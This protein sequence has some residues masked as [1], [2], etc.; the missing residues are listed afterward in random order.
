MIKTTNIAHPLK[1]RAGSS[2][3][4][5]S[6]E[7]LSPAYAPIDDKTL[8]DRLF[9]ISKYASLINYYEIQK[10]PE[11][12]EYQQADNWTDFFEN[13]LPFKLA[14]FSKISTEDLEDRFSLL[15]QALKDNPSQYTLEALLNFIYNEIILSTAALYSEVIKSESS[16]S[17]AIL[18]IIKSSFQEPLRRFISL[19]NAATTLLCITR[20]KFDSFLPEP[21]GLSVSEIYAI[22]ICI[23]QVKKGK[24][25]GYFLAGEIA[26]EIFAQFLSGLAEIIEAAPDYIQES[27]Y[28]LEA[29]MQKKHE[30]HLAL[31]FTFLE[32]FKH[33]QGNINGLGK[34]HLDFFYKKVLQLIPKDAVPDKAHI[35]FEIAKHLENGY[36]LPKDLLLKDGKDANKQDIQFGL[37]QELILDKSKIKELRS[38]S[39]YPVKDNNNIQHIEGVYITNV[40]NSLDGKGEKFKEKSANWATLG[41]KYTKQ[42]ENGKEQPNE[43]PK[44]RLGFVLASPVLLLQEG[45]RQVTITLN[46]DLFD[47]EENL[48]EAEKDILIDDIE[49]KLSVSGTE[50]LYLLSEF[51]IKECDKSLA[52]EDKLSPGATKYVSKLLVAQD[53]F[54]IKKEKLDEFLKA[55]DPVSCEPLFTPNDKVQITNCLNSLGFASKTIKQP[56]FRIFFSGEK[57]WIE[58]SSTLSIIK[59][60]LGGA[61]DF[62]FNFDITLDPEVPPVVFYNEENLKEKFDL[63]DIFPLVKIELNEELKILC[64]NEDSREEKCCLRNEP[65][66]TTDFYISP[67]ELLQDMFITD[68]KIEVTVCGVKNL[69][70]QNDETLQDVNKPIMPFGPR[71]KVKSSFIIGSKEVFCKKWESFRLNLEWK[72]RPDDFNNY[73]EA[74]N[75]IPPP[76]ITDNIFE[77][78][79]NI[80]EDANWKKDGTKKLFIPKENFPPCPVVNPLPAHNGYVWNRADFPIGY[81]EK[82]MPIPPLVPFNI[83]SR[84]AF[85]RL[86]LKGED[87]QHDRYA[88]VLAQQMFKLSQVAD[89]IK[90]G[91][92]LDDVD[93]GCLLAT[94]A[95]T[96]VDT[97]ETEAGGGVGSNISQDLIDQ[98]FGPP[99]PGLDDVSDQLMNVVCGLRTQIENITGG[100]LPVLPNEPY[101]PLIKSLSID[102]K[103]VADKVDMELIHLYPYE[104]TS[105]HENIEEKPTLLPYF[106]DE[107][108]L[109]I[110]LEE[111]TAG[112]NLSLLF[113]LAEATADSEQNRAKINW[114]YLSNN[115]WKPL[116]PEFDILHDATDG[117]TVSGII[118]IALPDDIHKKGHSI[119]PDDVFWLKV[120]TPSN[121][122]AVAET[123]GI[124]TQAAL[125]SARFG[126]L[127]DKQRLDSPLPAGSISKTLNSDF[128]VKK[129][130]QLYDS[131][132]GRQPE[133]SGHFYVRVSEQLK[134]KNRGIMIPDYEKIILEAFPEIYKVKCISH[135]MGL[136]ANEYRRDLEI[137]PGYLIIAVIPDL[138]KLK[139]GNLMN[140]K[141]PVSLLEKVG[142]HIRKKVSA[143]ARIKVMN[144]RYEPIDVNIEVRLYR[145]KSGNFYARK[146]KEEI[147]QFLAPWFLG[148]S[149]KLAF[150]QEVIFS[151]LV[152]FVEQREYIDFIKDIELKGKCEQEGPTIKPLTARSILTGGEVCVKINEEECDKAENRNEI[153]IS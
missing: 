54:E 126:K 14:N 48:S 129:V 63:K 114:Y 153:I 143:F 120:S 103:A 133:V 71:P 118:S 113:Q 144:P 108:T 61:A 93:L 102:Y 6:P 98:L 66:L 101:T 119:M 90:M 151:D 147:S 33:L 141:V 8:G 32:L 148:D 142:D 76:T 104:D 99:N 42:V 136:S 87:F 82:S 46:C 15:L 117:L 139:S 150:G 81:K 4:N 27:L 9:L 135:S 124:H 20:K 73:Y 109:F 50:T 74:Y 65:D 152:G 52:E 53:P 140:P 51:F 146:L 112:G 43:H 111:V 78:E 121:V 21:W 68:A 85:F 17:T 24:K 88:F 116:L 138:G 149:E 19:Y 80:L 134:H 31:L 79:A 12:K 26:V 41:D 3:G 56:L 89:L 29:S 94:D 130:S 70:V 96:K 122:K 36:Q 92:F 131:F 128:N 60:P 95:E 30:P 18:S 44:A 123:I 69:I 55:I 57:E 13:S 1:N 137:A 49:Q 40:A 37:D 34:K 28:P 11:N 83:T 86:E 5:R 62:Q 10:D 25:A 115:N 125:T 23:Q 75:Q 22:D 39:L 72:D 35:V 145:G 38:L 107:G 16:F 77:I 2:Q 84:K 58:G 132:G 67:Y 64:E 7:A 110:G 59:K 97:I 105:K 45:K 47:G 127:S 100:T 106:E 91:D